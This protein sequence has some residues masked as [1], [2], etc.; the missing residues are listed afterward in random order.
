[1]ISLTKLTR[2]NPVKSF[3]SQTLIKDKTQQL[4]YNRIGEEIIK[5]KSS[6]K[7]KRKEIMLLLKYNRIGKENNKENSSNKWNK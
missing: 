1:M 7:E 6:K 2:T 4:K 5:E 3:K